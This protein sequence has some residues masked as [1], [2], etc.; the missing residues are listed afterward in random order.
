MLS[1]VKHEKGFIN[2]GPGLLRARLSSV[3]G[4]L[5]ILLNNGS[6]IKNIGSM[7]MFWV[8]PW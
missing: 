2:S 7:H 4:G 6:D 8:E 5:Y 1:W 3:L